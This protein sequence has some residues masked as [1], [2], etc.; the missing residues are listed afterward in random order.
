M[1]LRGRLGA[2]LLVFLLT[3]VPAGGSSGGALVV[4]ILPDRILLDSGQEIPL[5][6]VRAVFLVH[7]GGQVPVPWELIS[8][9]DRVLGLEAGKLR[10]RTRLV[11]GEFLD[12][13]HGELL[14]GPENLSLSSRSEVL[15]NGRPCR[16]EDLPRGRVALA[17]LD[18]VTGQVWRLEV[19]DPNDP[20]G[21]HEHSEV[22][23]VRAGLD[24]L[25]EVPSRPL[26][27]KEVL[28]LA[29]R[30]PRGGLAA[31][32]VAGVVQGLPAREVEPGLYRARLVVPP[33]LDAPRTFVLGRFL[34]SGG[35][36]S[37][38]VGPVLSLAPSPPGI[39]QFGPRGRA[40]GRAPIFVRLESPGASVE[41]SRIRLWLDG[42][43]I[44]T[45]VIRRVDLVWYEP[46]T[47][48]PAGLHRVR[49]SLEDTA[50]NRTQESWVFQ[51]EEAEVE[52]LSNCSRTSFGWRTP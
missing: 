25:E 41:P 19:V 16:L 24:P 18:P 33:G 12:A 38:R 47:E 23:A 45:G 7:S 37:I 8:P 27:A 43:E 28:H 44:R 34:S 20:E 17:R 39:L 21:E 49:V 15:L 13:R 10:I 29:L 1:S 11:R 3:C 52:E 30:A 2:L 51:V 50:G 4:E 6:R 42:R 31:F 35:T 22:L 40:W 9:G 14:L 5:A 46:P 26:R 36:S 48:L 32:D